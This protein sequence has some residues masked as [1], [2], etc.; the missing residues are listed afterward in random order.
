LWLRR[1]PDFADFRGSRLEAVR[2]DDGAMNNSSP[3]TASV[4]SGSNARGKRSVGKRDRSEPAL[5]ED[6]LFAPRE[7]SM[8]A[9]V[10]RTKIFALM[11][12]GS[13]PYIRIGARRRIPKRALIDYLEARLVKRDGVA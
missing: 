13:L 9:K 1:L 12:D 6:G 4:P 2:D 10:G 8:F 3:L 5:C 11:A 7:A